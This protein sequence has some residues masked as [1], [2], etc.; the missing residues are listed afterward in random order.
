MVYY[1]T[2]AT[3]QQDN[4]KILNTTFASLS[5]NLT[6]I[7]CKIGANNHLH[8]YRILNLAPINSTMLSKIFCSKAAILD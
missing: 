3:L 1:K 7:F 8:N 2:P 4:K 6:C 5:K